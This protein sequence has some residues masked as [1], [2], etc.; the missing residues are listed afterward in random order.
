MIRT[1]TIGARDSGVYDTIGPV[2]ALEIGTRHDGVVSNG[3]TADP[4][5]TDRSAP[6]P[7][8]A[9]LAIAMV[10]MVGCAGGTTDRSASDGDAIILAT[11]SS[12]YD[13]GLL[14]RLIERFEAGDVRRVKMIVVGSGQALALA[15]RGEADIVLVHAPAAERRFM[16][17]G[18]GH[19][20]RRMMY[21]DFILVGPDD[22]PASVAGAEGILPAMRAIVDSGSI[23][24]SRGDESGTHQLEKRLWDRLSFRPRLG[25]IYLESGQGMAATLLIASAKGAYTLTDR[26][27]YLAQRDGLAL[28]IL[29]EGDPLLRN[30]Y[31]LIVVDPGTGPWVN[32]AGAES[33]AR[34]LL[35]EEALA[36][37]GDFGRERYGQPL[38]VP[39]PEPYGSE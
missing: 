16:N 33:L 15:G 7:L 1:R 30:V 34:F 20:R 18:G 36:I 8:L 10:A 37:V 2:D 3:I 26:G 35:S 4:I 38:F 21:N 32:L 9:A 28:A 19:R 25:R 11:T 14:D 23:F 24:V 29:S 17:G 5:G 31:H 12:T 27:T 39:D 6:R 22:D 13:T